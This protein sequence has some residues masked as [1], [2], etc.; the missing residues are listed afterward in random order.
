[1]GEFFMAI[2][3]NAPQSDRAKKEIARREFKEA[4]S[5]RLVGWESG[6]ILEEE[7]GNYH[8]VENYE[9]EDE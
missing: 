7:V 5:Q 1:M 9:P 6:G 3:R 4:M 8:E 2:G